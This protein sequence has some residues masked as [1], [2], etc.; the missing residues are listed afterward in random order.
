MVCGGSMRKSKRISVAAGVLLL[1]L[2][3]TALA[4]DGRAQSTFTGIVKDQTGAVLPGV[5]VEASSPVL[6]EKSRSI[7]TDERGGY[8]IIDLRTGVSTLTF[9]LPGFTSIRLV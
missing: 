9:R 3:L 8:K 7:F 5:S 4:P 2:C 6:I 1:F